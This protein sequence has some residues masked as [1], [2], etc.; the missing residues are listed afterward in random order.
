MSMQSLFSLFSLLF[1]LHVYN[2][3][4]YFIMALRTTTFVRLAPASLA[5]LIRVIGK[6]LTHDSGVTG[7]ALAGNLQL[8]L[9]LAVN[10][11]K[12][13]IYLH[14]VRHFSSTAFAIS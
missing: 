1:L 12:F 8:L 2:Y 5:A 7:Q 10:S 11:V 9:G 14:D 4:H 6:C 13:L 3:F